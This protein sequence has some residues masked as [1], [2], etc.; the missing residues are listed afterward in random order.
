MGEMIPMLFGKILK[1][2]SLFGIKTEL[3]GLFPSRQNSVESSR[4][5]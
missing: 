2:R 1:S 5:V 4:A 3:S